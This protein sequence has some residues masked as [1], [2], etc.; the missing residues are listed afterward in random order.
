MIPNG[1]G[2]F[3]P[4]WRIFSEPAFVPDQVRDGL[5]PENIL[6]KRSR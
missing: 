5:S 6:V 1:G 4:A 2:I 3:T